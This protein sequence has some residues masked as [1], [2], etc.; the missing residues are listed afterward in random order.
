MIT[1]PVWMLVVIIFGTAILVAFLMASFAGSNYQDYET[2]IIKKNDQL[3]E[4][5]SNYNELNDKYTYLKSEYTRLIRIH[6]MVNTVN[7]N[8]PE[9]IKK[10]S[11]N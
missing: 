1:I 11:K 6:D 7:E 10:Q 9:Q 5:I 3:K 2:T 8:V 4:N